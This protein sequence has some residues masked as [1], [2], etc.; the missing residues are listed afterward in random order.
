[1]K[2]VSRVVEGAAGG[3]HRTFLLIHAAEALGDA[4]VAAG[5]AGDR[6]FGE[7]G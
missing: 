3:F 6:A 4:G 5:E 1:M 2:E 7:V